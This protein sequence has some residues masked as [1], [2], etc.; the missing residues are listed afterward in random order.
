[1]VGFADGDV[2]A[3]QEMID[4]LTD[5]QYLINKDLYEH[6]SGAAHDLEGWQGEAADNFRD[7]LAAMKSGIDVYAQCPDSL[8]VILRAQQALILAM[9]GDALQLVDTTLKAIEATE[10]DDLQI[11][12]A[13]VGA[14]ASVLAAP[15]TGGVVGAVIG[16]MAASSAGTSVTNEVLDA[17]R[18]VRPDRPDIITAP[19][20]DPR[21]FEPNVDGRQPTKPTNTTDLVPEPQRRPD[22][23][24]DRRTKIELPISGEETEIIVPQGGE[25]V[26]EEQG[27][28]GRAALRRRGAPVQPDTAP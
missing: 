16:T 13:V 7:Y 10:A 5:A 20:F 15:A 19:S 25:D 24:H 4:E 17:L 23:P 6:F 8:I 3:V 27:R 14:V 18:E 1:M 21:D 11:V 2:D 12:L 9:R 26:Y 22:G 28:P